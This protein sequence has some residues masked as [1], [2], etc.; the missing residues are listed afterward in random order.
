MKMIQQKV[1]QSL[2]S[3]LHKTKAIQADFDLRSTLSMQFF[4]PSYS[5]QDQMN[6]RNL[7]IGMFRDKSIWEVK[8]E[9]G[10][11]KVRFWG[12]YKNQRAC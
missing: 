9:K 3:Y 11:K 8:R 5:L 4:F 10:E 2:T 1:T 7:I 6:K 12:N